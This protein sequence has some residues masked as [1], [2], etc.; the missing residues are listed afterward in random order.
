MTL[1]LKSVDTSVLNIIAYI[2]YYVAKRFEYSPYW[3]GLAVLIVLCN[4]ILIL[5]KFSVRKKQGLQLGAKFYVNAIISVA[6][7]LL[8]STI[9]S[10]SL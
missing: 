6:L 10:Q 7:L 8:I 3:Y 9:Y 5:Y 2:A 4:I 1:S